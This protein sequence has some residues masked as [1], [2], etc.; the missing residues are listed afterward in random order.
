MNCKIC[1]KKENKNWL[2]SLGLHK[3]YKEIGLQGVMI[4]HHC[5]RCHDDFTWI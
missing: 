4:Y 3:W 2:C 1:D 5:V